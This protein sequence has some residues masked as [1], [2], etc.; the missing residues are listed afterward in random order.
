MVTNNAFLYGT[1]RSSKARLL[2]TAE[3]GAKN[4]TVEPGLD[5]QV[6]ETIGLA[7]TNMRTMDFDYCVIQSYN[8]GS[9]EIECVDELEGFHFGAFESTFDDY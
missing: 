9:G 2:R 1:P 3:V 5:W 8:S 4:I 6:G 7:A